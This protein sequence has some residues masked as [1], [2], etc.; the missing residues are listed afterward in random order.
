[1]DTNQLIT[2][3]IKQK[4]VAMPDYDVSN[5]AVVAKYANKELPSSKKKRAGITPY[6][7]VWDAKLATH[8][9]KRAMFGVKQSEINALVALGSADAAVNELVNAVPNLMPIPV[10]YYEAIYPDSTLT[11][12]L[13]ST[14]INAAEGDGSTNYYRNIG[15]KGQWLRSMIEQNMSIYEK[16]TLFWHNHIPVEANVVNDARF[17]Y[18]YLNK[19]RGYTLGN[20]KALVKDITTE[21]AMLFYLNGYVNNKF[22]PDE[23]YAREL[24]ELFTVGKDGG[25]QYSEDDVKAAARALTGWRIDYPNITSYFEPTFHDTANK[26]FSSFYGS[27]TVAGQSGAA[28]GQA[29]LDALINMVFSGQSGLTTAKYVCRELYK[30]FVYYNIDA[31]TEA[32]VIT[33]LA[34]TFIANNWEIKPVLLQL[35]KSDHF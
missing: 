18:R 14:W 16:L 15:L 3:A 21:G 35:F 25:P 19:I 28:A 27:T 32:N 13:G 12:P 11:V 22:S 5:D 9:L 20:F 17:M 2:N 31:N 10:N 23:N 33:P 24:Q 26:V 34:N 8:L 29:E 4:K 30:F 7:G 1:M 6:T